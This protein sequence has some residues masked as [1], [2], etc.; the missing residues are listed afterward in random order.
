IWMMAAAIA[1]GVLTAQGLTTAVS[2]LVFTFVLEC[3]TAM[4]SPTWQAI[5][6]E[7]ISRKQLRNAV[8]LNALGINVARAIGPAI[9]GILVASA[10]P[11]TAFLIN[12]VSF[13]GVAGVLF[14]WRKPHVK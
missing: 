5:V 7:L 6:P 8:T 9:G 4:S 3:G 14:A 13:L 11:A 10:G 1:L 2:L 12:A